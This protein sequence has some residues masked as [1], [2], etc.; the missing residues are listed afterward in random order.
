MWWGTGVPGSLTL[1]VHRD[2]SEPE[3]ARD[4]GEENRRRDRKLG[5][6]WTMTNR[7]KILGGCRERQEEGEAE[8]EEGRER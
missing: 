3:A 6:R 2:E 5:G 8:E 7:E 4:Q 1:T